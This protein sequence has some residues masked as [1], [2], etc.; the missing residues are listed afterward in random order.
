MYCAISSH[1]FSIKFDKLIERC[2]NDFLIL[3]EELIKLHENTKKIVDFAAIYDF[4][5]K[6]PG[7]GFRSFIHVCLSA[8]DLIDEI[9]DNFEGR[10]SRCICGNS[11]F[12]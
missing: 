8:V 2:G 5:E 6:T 4:D 1:E 12:R 7:N 11:N 3:K 10:C 9:F